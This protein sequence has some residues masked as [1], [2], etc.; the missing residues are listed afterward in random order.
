MA[1]THRSPASLEV[2]FHGETVV[3]VAL[4]PAANVTGW[5]IVFV[6]MDGETDVYSAAA[7]VTDAAVGKF[8]VTL[9]PDLVVA[10]GGGSLDPHRVYDYAFRRTD[11]G[12]R[13]PGLAYGPL[14]FKLR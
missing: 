11:S 7:T 14:R 3:P 8:N 5:T 12:A 9:A 1:D 4:N 6:I 10:T 2:W 13:D